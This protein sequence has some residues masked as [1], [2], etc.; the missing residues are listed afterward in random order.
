[1]FRFNLFYNLSF[2]EQA[3][4]D[5]NSSDTVTPVI[6]WGAVL[7]LCFNYMLRLVPGRLSLF[8]SELKCL[9]S[10]PQGFFDQNGNDS[11]WGFEE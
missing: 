5:S 1:M 9:T 10:K 11:L 8:S 4:L 2:I 3:C 7:L 6:L